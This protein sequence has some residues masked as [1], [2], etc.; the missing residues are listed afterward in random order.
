MA[1]IG[2]R[3][4]EIRKKVGLTQS[5][6][7]D[8]FGVDRGHISKIESGK[9]NPSKQLIKSI[10]RSFYIREAWVLEGK[11]PIKEISLPAAEEEK[12]KALSAKKEIEYIII[13]LERYTSLLKDILPF[14]GHILE[15]TNSLIATAKINPYYSELLLLEDRKLGYY[16]ILKKIQ[17]VVKPLQ[18]T[19]KGELV[20]NVNIEANL[21]ENR[22]R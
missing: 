16:D 8:L 10:C 18:E 5:R 1:H 12:F 2:K 6:F 22:K 14:I 20:D 4:K 19:I 17:E 9:A 3:I 7:A 15:I 11:E 21:I 13:N